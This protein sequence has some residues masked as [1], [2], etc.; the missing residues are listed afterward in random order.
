[1]DGA[2]RTVRPAPPA[3]S[4]RNGRPVPVVALHRGHNARRGEP[5]RAKSRHPDASNEKKWEAGRATELAA[6]LG[7]TNAYDGAI[8]ASERGWQV[9]DSGTDP[10]T[11]RWRCR[12]A[13]MQRT[14]GDAALKP[15]PT[16][17][18]VNGTRTRPA[19]QKRAAA[20]PARNAGRE[21]EKA[22]GTVGYWDGGTIVR[23]M[24]SESP[25]VLAAA[26]DGHGSIRGS[27]YAELLARRHVLSGGDPAGPF[28]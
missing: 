19:T 6:R 25:A 28:R 12:Q 23:R 21:L 24:R 18:P 14:G 22:T 1:M 11:K 17:A 8:T 5:F 3:V 13:A 7:M 27:K 26:A 4:H 9:Y 15:R 20:G 10:H 16:S 2:P